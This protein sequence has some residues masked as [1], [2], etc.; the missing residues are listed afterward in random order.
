MSRIIFGVLFIIG[1]ASGQLALRGTNSSIA[2]VVV[3]VIFVV[4]GIVQLSS[5]DEDSVYSAVETKPKNQLSVVNDDKIVVY[6]KSHESLGTLTELSYGQKFRVDLA[7][8]YDRFYQVV[9]GDGKT[10]YILKTSRFSPTI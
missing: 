4:I 5:K 3:G 7:T 2:L 8:D 9:T 1:G 6:N 10:G